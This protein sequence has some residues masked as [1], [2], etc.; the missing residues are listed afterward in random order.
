MYPES[1]CSLYWS[2]GTLIK[3]LRGEKEN[4]KFYQFI[5]TVKAEIEK[6]WGKEYEV[7][8]QKLL[9]NNGE[10]RIGIGI[11]KK[12]DTSS[13]LVYLNSYYENLT[14]GEMSMQHI[15][16][17][18]YTMFMDK[19]FPDI[20]DIELRD[21]EKLKEKVTYRLV[22]RELNEELLK[23]VPYVPYCD[24]AIVFHLLLDINGNSQMTSLI[25]EEHIKLWETNV[26]TLYKLAKENT[27]RLF[28]FKIRTLNDVICEIAS[29]TRTN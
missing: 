10:K 8:I 28:P 1:S 3:D 11:K 4:M 17:D 27:P 18:I 9:G 12:G 25:H 23:D 6:L 21:F 7:L 29:M 13:P 26:E 16:K 5:K 15:V 24:L 22:N 20:P 19:L 14:A 2:P